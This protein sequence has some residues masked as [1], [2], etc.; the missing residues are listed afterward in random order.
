MASPPRPTLYQI[1]IGQVWFAFL[2]FLFGSPPWDRFP[3]SF[4][5]ASIAIGVAAGLASSLLLAL[6]PDWLLR[7][8]GQQLR[9]VVERY[10][11]PILAPLGPAG[12]IV[13]ALA[14]GIGEEFFFRG[15][16]QEAFVQR[17][18]LVMGILLASGI[19]GLIHW[20]HWSI[21]LFTGLLGIY[22][23][24]LYHLSGNIVVP[25]LAHTAHNIV[26]FFLAA[27]LFGYPV[28]EERV[29]QGNGL[30]DAVSSARDDG[31]PPVDQKRSDLT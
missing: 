28:R 13:V 23:G 3:Y 29:Q 4:D 19:F 31:I 20:M 30:A 21:V 24:L 11:W 15:F 12:W 1:L 7:S 14:A 26:S 17:T 2:G 10:Q 27:K 9:L 5:V 8:L 18:N 6:V 22:F 16:V 25:I